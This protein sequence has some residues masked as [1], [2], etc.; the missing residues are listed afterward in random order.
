MPSEATVVADAGAATQLIPGVGIPSL[1]PSIE[2]VALEYITTGIGN[3]TDTP[4]M[5]FEQVK[6]R[7]YAFST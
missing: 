7:P 3:T 4:Q 2:A 5:V 6:A 1:A